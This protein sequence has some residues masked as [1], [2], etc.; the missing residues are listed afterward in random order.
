M[1]VAAAST[2]LVAEEICAQLVECLSELFELIGG[3]RVVRV[4]RVHRSRLHSFRL[5]N[6]VPAAVVL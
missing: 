3:G 1:A 6:L 2:C 5:R 4:E